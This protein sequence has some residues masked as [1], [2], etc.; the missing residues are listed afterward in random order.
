MLIDLNIYQFYCKVDKMFLLIFRCILGQQKHMA[1][2][3]FAVKC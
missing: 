3:M 1:V 2:S